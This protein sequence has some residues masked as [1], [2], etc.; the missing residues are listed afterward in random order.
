MD[1]DIF[2]TVAS[3]TVL[4]PHAIEAIML[5]FGDRTVFGATGLVRVLNRRRNVLT[6]LID[7]RYANAFLLDSRRT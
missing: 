2:V 3:D 1:A 5:A 6:R 7:L 4:D